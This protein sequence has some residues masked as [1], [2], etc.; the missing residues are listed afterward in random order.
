LFKDNP[1]LFLFFLILAGSN[2]YL[3]LNPRHQKR[4]RQNIFSEKMDET[5][6]QKLTLILLLHTLSPKNSRFENWYPRLSGHQRVT[7]KP[8]HDH[9]GTKENE[10]DIFFY[11]KIEHKKRI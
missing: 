7:M 5:L 10:N 6:P 1:N 4:N 8:W 2:N 3:K 9:K 11:L